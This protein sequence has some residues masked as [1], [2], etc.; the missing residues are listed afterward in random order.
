MTTSRPQLTNP[1]RVELTQLEFD[2]RL[3][4]ACRSTPETAIAAIGLLRVL[5]AIGIK[6]VIEAIGMDKIV[7]YFVEKYGFD[8]FI[9]L[10]LEKHGQ[11]A[12]EFFAQSTAGILPS[13][14]S[15]AE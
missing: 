15:R 5:E 4:W 12:N 2:R 13:S 3:V 7:E 8:G 10:L 14:P 1:N 6:R 9:A 11:Q